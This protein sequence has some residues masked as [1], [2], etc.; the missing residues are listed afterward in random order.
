MIRF[1]RLLLLLPV[2]VVL[3]LFLVANTGSVT[4]SFWPLPFSVDAPAYAVPFIAL[5]LG[6]ILGGGIVWL[7]MAL[8]R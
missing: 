5:L 8:R 1:F 7:K 4:W 3:G 6:L 2:I